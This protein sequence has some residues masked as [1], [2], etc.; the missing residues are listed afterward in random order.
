MANSLMAYM[1]M[2]SEAKSKKKMKHGNKI[3]NE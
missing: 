3:S 2:C 1:K